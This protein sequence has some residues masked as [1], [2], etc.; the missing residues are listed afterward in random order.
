MKF[1]LRF[2]YPFNKVL[3][4]DE[5]VLEVPYEGIY[6]YELYDYLKRRWPEFYTLLD[7]SNLLDDSGYPNALAVVN[8]S[9]ARLDTKIEN[10][11]EL[12]LFYQADGG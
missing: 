5:L 3:E 4:K 8:G 1:R 7:A 6:F 2:M 10:Q 12:I 11:D 9:V